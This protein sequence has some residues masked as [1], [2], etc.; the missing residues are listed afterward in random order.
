M[1][2]LIKIAPES[3][4]KL[5]DHIPMDSPARDAI[6]KATPIEHAVEGVLFAGYSIVCSEAQARLLLDFAKQ[7]CP[8]ATSDIAKALTPS[9][10]A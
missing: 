1:D 10:R 6:E 7:H 4:R 8:E 3:Y 2:I 5:R 9:A